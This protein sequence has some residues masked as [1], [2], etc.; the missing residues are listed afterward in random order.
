LGA[1]RVDDVAHHA[2]K[3]FNDVF[4]Q[5]QEYLNKNE[6]I[7][8]KFKK[9]QMNEIAERIRQCSYLS[10][11]MVCEDCLTAHYVGTYACKTRYCYSCAKKRGLSLLYRYGTIL[12]QYEAD[13]HQLVF[14][15][16]T[17]KN[18]SNLKKMMKKFNKDMECFRAYNY[19]KNRVLGSIACREVTYNFK[20]DN[21]HFHAHIIIVLNKGATIIN[22]ELSLEWLKRT[23]DSFIVDCRPTKKKEVD[24]VKLNTDFMELFKYPTKLKDI[25][26][27]PDA[28]FDE[29]YHSFFKARLISTSGCLYG[30][31]SDEAIDNDIDGLDTRD[32]EKLCCAV[33]SGTSLFP[34]SHVTK[35]V[36][37]EVFRLKERELIV[38]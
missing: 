32:L 35:D 26:F 28:R 14:M 33:C 5:Y 6:Y 30:A 36:N 31:V 16:L 8:N 24:G 2:Q 1:V 9:I 27:L 34:Y 15:T 3:V 4:K 13:G 20:F 17:A 11:F 12:N 38:D 21:W 7:I 19:W 25:S 23:G 29:L 22:K 18:E 10:N 37:F